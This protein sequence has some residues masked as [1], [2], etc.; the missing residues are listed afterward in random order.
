MG[1]H[2]DSQI[3]QVAPVCSFYAL[4]GSNGLSV[5]YSDAQESVKV[6]AGAYE[7]DHD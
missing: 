2:F 5:A 7:E 6:H 4:D 3:S 1:P